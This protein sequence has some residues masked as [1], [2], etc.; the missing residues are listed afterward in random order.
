MLLK[1]LLKPFPHVSYAN[2]KRSLL[3]FENVTQATCEIAWGTSEPFQ[4]AAFSAG[5]PNLNLIS[6]FNNQ[7]LCSEF[8]WRQVTRASAGR[9]IRTPTHA[10]MLLS[11]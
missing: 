5:A 6:R 11:V 10:I 4:A 7:C 1:R 8:R 2:E 3:A 9:T